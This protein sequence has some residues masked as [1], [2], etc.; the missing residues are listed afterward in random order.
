MSTTYIKQ[1]ICVAVIWAIIPAISFAN[2]QGLAAII[3]Y[4]GPCVI[5]YGDTIAPPAIK[6]DPLPE[7]KKLPLV[8]KVPKSRRQVK[9]VPLPGVKPIIKPKIIKPVVAVGI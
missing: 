3:R 5:F 8:K 7:P 1:L 6:E 4:D 2:R 9:P